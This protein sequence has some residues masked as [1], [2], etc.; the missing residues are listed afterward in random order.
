MSELFAE[1]IKYADK[2]RELKNEITEQEIRT[3]KQKYGRIMMKGTKE[4]PP[5][6]ISK[7]QKGKRERPRQN[8]AKNLLDST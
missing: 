7:S 5:P 4:N 2:K 8:E 3:L 6:K 1:Y